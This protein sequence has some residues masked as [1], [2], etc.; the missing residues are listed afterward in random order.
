MTDTPLISVIMPTNNEAERIGDALYSMTRQTYRNLEILV[1][2]DHSTDGTRAIIEEWV[3][4]DSRVKY[5]LLPN[6]D[7]KRTHILPH[8]TLGWRA[9]DINGGYSARNYGFSIARGAYITLQDADDASVANRIE[10]QYT[11]LKKYDATLVATQWM[12]FKRPYM[13]KGLDIERIF[14]NKGEDALIVHPE[15]ISAMAKRNKGV[16]MRSWFPHQ[17]IPFIFKWFPG[18][19]PLFFKGYENYPGADNSMLFKREV[20]EKVLFRKRDDR[21]WPNPYGRGSGRDFAFQVAETF[22]NSWS[23]HLPLYLWRA[24]TENPAFTEY[25]QY[26]V[27]IT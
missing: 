4:K 2:D 8:R 10:V 25:E 20:I 16:L 6:P 5:F 7:P 22:S 26:L 1:V 3:K 24:T 14:A 12:G 27:D 9:Y 15:A 21:V 19:R 18:T 17:Y 23:F 13:D 11:L